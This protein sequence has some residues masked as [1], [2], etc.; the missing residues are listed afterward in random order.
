MLIERA[1][2]V[3]TRKQLEAA[4]LMRLMGIPFICIPIV[5]DDQRKRIEAEFSDAMAAIELAAEG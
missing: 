3:E 2:P 5:S 1:N 4:N